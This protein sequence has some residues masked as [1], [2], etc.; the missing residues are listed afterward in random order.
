MKGLTIL[1]TTVL[2]F[3]EIGGGGGGGSEVRTVRGTIIGAA[4]VTAALVRD[5]QKNV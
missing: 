5:T 2:T 1:I 3:T 4:I